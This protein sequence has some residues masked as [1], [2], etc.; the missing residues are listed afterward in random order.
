MIILVELLRILMSEGVVFL[1]SDQRPKDF[2][3]PYLDLEDDGSN[4]K[5]EAHIICGILERQ[6]FW[7][8]KV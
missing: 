7:L 1:F 4:T 3:S 6:S 5:S 8:D 2:S